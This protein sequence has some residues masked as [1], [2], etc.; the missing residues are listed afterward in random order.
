VPD[1]LPVPGPLDV[2]IRHPPL[3]AELARRFTSAPLPAPDQTVADLTGTEPLTAGDMSLPAVSTRVT[4]TPGRGDGDDKGLIVTI[5]AL[6]SACL[7]TW[8]QG[9]G[10]QPSPAVVIGSGS[11]AKLQRGGPWMEIFAAV[12]GACDLHDKSRESVLAAIDDVGGGPA[13]ARELMTLVMRAAS[14]LERERLEADMGT[15]SPQ[16][17][18]FKEAYADGYA[19]GLQRG[20]T[21]R[22]IVLVLTTRGIELTDTQ[23]E[24]IAACDDGDQLARWFSRAV[25]AAT[26][27]E[28][29]A[30]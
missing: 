20:R 28:V 26:A 4:I 1:N 25:T 2:I 15:N 6:N 12:I 16:H 8:K 19:H 24:Q 27:D 30:A 9:P 21:E 13:G 22:T 17:L 11:R 29:L 3:A 10:G 23:R 5:A 18:M 14:E 7:L